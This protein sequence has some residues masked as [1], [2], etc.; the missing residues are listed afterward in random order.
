MQTQ[1]SDMTK[2]FWRSAGSWLVVPMAVLM[3]VNFGRT[4]LDPIGFAA[5]L[6]LPLQ[7]VADFCLIQLY[8]LRALF[9][10]LFASYL[11]WREKATE[12][13]WFAWLAIVMPVGDACLV[14]QAGGTQAIIVRHCLT[15][16]YLL[17]AGTV[18]HR[19]FRKGVLP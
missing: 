12:L 17:V 5:Y 11:L 15:A 3:L 19:S 6:G 16:V 1:L 2:T 9:I 4:L 8:G 7:N 10:G 13:K 14:W 18:L